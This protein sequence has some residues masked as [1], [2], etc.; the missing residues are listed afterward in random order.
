MRSQVQNKGS[1]ST[2]SGGRWGYVHFKKLGW[3][4]LWMPPGSCVGV[5]THILR[6]VEQRKHK[7]NVLLSILQWT[8]TEVAIISPIT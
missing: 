2:S 6:Q 5:F 8:V 7:E 3:N 1:W 4:Y